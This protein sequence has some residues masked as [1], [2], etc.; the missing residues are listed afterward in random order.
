MQRDGS[1]SGARAI[2]RHVERGAAELGLAGARRQGRSRPGR[3]R[4]EGRERGDEKGGERS[5]TQ[6]PAT[7]Q[8]STE[9][10]S[11][12]RRLDLE[13]S[14]FRNTLR[15]LMA[16]GER[17]TFGRRRVAEQPPWPAS[18]AGSAAPRRSSPCSRARRPSRCCT[19]T[20][21]W[22]LLLGAAGHLRARSSPSAASSTSSPQADPAREP[23][24]R[25]SRAA[26]GRH[27]RAAARLVLAHEVPPAV[28]A[29][30][31][32]RAAR[33]RSCCYGLGGTPQRRPR[34]SIVRRCCRS[35]A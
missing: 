32:G 9:G 24:R 17:T 31:R 2:E 30:A 12:Y 14:L 20:H 4:C 16:N 33:S 8:V 1:R 18:G 26:R 7:V 3:G 13:I 21:D 11:R 22:P 5:G 15:G 10:R 35:A 23:V 6:G 28:L 25:R 19:A 29:R 27:R 34:R